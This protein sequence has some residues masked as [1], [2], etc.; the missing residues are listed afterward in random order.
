[1]VVATR[2]TMR[3]LDSLFCAPTT[4]KFKPMGKREWA[5]SYIYILKEGQGGMAAMNLGRIQWRRLRH[6]GREDRSDM[7]AHCQRDRACRPKQC[8]A[9]APGPIASES[10]GREHGCGGKEG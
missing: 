6:S 5:A 10:R 8:G 2:P 7:M 1:M 3:A 9:D 4:T